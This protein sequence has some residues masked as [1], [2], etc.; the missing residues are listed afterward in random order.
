MSLDR[1]TPARLGL[2]RLSELGLAV[3]R[4]GPQSPR[5]TIVYIHGLGESS[6]CFEA[7]ISDPRLDAWQHLAIDLLGYGRSI[8]PERPFDLEQHAASI[9]LLLDRLQIDQAMLVGHSM[10]SVVALL[11]AERGS[12]DIPFLLDVEGN[13]T[14]DDCTF[15]SIASGQTLEHWLE[16][17]YADF[18][19]HIHFLAEEG[20]D[21]SDAAKEGARVMR[22][23]GASA[24]FA[25][26]RTLYRDAVDLVRLSKTDELAARRAATGIPMVHFHGT[27][28]GTGARSLGQLEAAGIATRAFEPAGHWPFLDQ[29]DA[30][31]EA[32]VAALE[33]HS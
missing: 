9:E 12:L 8:W 26:P 18:I 27:P 24:H 13:V 3:R 10:G 21:T 11:L 32:M 25:D 5:A 33:E 17:G 16:A 29:H 14:F 31:V 30:F 2:E 4:R 22:A 7:L 6:L 19:D 28:R 20:R 1:F 15:S 23:Y